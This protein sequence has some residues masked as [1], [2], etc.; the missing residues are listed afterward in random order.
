M[1]TALSKQH[2]RVYNTLAK[3]YEKNVPNYYKS[4]NEA[5][6]ILSKCLKSK[7]EVLDVGCG[8]G[9]ASELLS[10]KGY[11][12][13][14][15]DI[16][17]SMIEYTQ[18]RCPNGKTI[19]GDFLTYKFENNYDAII[20]LAFIHLFPKI[21][22][23]KIID[24]MFELLKPGGYLYVGTTKS[25]KS[26]EGWEL[27]QDAFYPKSIQKRFRKHWLENEFKES[28]VNSGFEFKNVYL[29]K[30]PRNKLWMDFLML[31]THYRSA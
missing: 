31:K 30:D 10:K 1:K 9:L 11:E 22:A 20:S 2:K 14:A 25:T 4:T 16:S 28:L 3:E 24:K 8:I 18:N 21:I 13:T 27:K 15:M 23:L 5:V 6:E 12:V 26:Y 7:A 29:L 17:E 19:V